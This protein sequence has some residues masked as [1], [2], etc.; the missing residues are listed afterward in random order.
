MPDPW[1]FAG[2]VALETSKICDLYTTKNADEILREIFAQMDGIV[3]RDDDD[4]STL[5]LMLLGRL[6]LGSVLMGRKVPDNMLARMMLLLIGSDR[7]AKRKMPDATA[8][9]QLQAALK[10]GRPVWWKMFARRFKLA[11]VDKALPAPKPGQQAVLDMSEAQ[12]R[13]EALREALVAA[14]IHIKPHGSEAA[15]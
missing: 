3:G 11:G 10:S 14:D 2:V 8:H 9:K 5:T 1:Y 4:A 7:A 12:A 6:G 13:R 15:A